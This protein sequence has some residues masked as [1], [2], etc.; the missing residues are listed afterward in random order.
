[1]VSQRI[2]W[3]P[4]MPDPIITDSQGGWLAV[5]ATLLG[6][7]A[8]LVLGGQKWMK[9]WAATNRDVT[10]IGA[11]T[12]VL[13]L[14]RDEVARLSTESSALRE[15]I[16]TMREEHA[17]ETLVLRMEVAELR[18]INSRLLAET[19]HWQGIVASLD[20]TISRSTQA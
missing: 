5:G 4:L 12:D 10:K 1:M 18:D 8:T 20:G 7:G 19:A 2:S 6:G 13:Q 16:I 3:N 9:T 14:L 11:E 17:K 15:S